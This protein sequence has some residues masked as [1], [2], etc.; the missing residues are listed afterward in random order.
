MTGPQT[1]GPAPLFD[2]AFLRK[3]ERLAVLSRRALAGQ[4]QG[5]RRSPKR[6]QSVEFADFR[7]YAPGDDFRRI[8]WNAYARLERFFLKLFVEEQDLTVHVLVDTSLSMDWGEP[9]KLRFGLRAAGALGYVALAGLDR[10][11]VTALGASGEGS[12]AYF[13]PHR[14]K[15]QANALFQFLVGLEARGTTDLRRSLGRYAARAQQPG[16]L[17]VISDL[18]DSAP[19][20]AGPANL[21]E[22]LDRREGAEGLNALAARGFEVTLLHVLSPDELR[23]ELAGDLKLRDLETGAEVEIT[24]DDALLRR[25]RDNLAAWQDDLRRFCG[26]RGMHY[27]PVE[28]TLPLEELLFAWLRQ[29]AVLR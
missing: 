13:P 17:I 27:V 26:P 8:D 18:M 24:A 9:N 16:P 12:P 15:Q 23:P 29:Q 25:Y 2:E 10:V 11:T 6:G 3:L 5:E 19:A 1:E 7:P 21:P 14:G 22:V 4:M 28:T 20:A